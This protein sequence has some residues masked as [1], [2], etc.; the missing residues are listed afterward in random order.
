MKVV[1]VMPSVTFGDAVSNDA[2]A[3]AKV[4][5]E[6]G[7]ST[8]IYAKSIGCG[9]DDR[10]VHGFASLPHLEADDVVIFNHS[11]GTDLCRVLGELGGRKLMI[12]HNITPPEF[13]RGYSAQLEIAMQNGYLG[14]RQVMSCISHVMAV[15]EY[16]ARS[17]REMGYTCPMTVRPILIPFSDYEREPNRDV[18]KRF[19][20]DGFVNI[21]FVGRIAPNKRQEDIIR[22]FAHYKKHFGVRSRLILVGND[23]GLETYGELLRG[24]VRA[25]G[26]DD[27][28]FAGHTDLPTLIAYYRVADVF[29]CMSEHE[30]FGVPL[31]EAMYFDVPII[32]YNSSAVGETLGGSG[33]LLDSKEPELVCRIIDRTVNDA[34]FRGGILEKQRAR[35][36]DLSYGRVRESFVRQLEAFISLGGQK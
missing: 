8:G 14:T 3:I 5:S 32:A 34:A 25:L 33:I 2:R 35:L 17:L 23:R 21:L 9:V 7:Y 16:N 28:I 27:V 30:G 11:T 22:A 13:F 15:S 4:I 6:L 10:L 19:S 29:L 20:N 36:A 18:M 12:Y 26:V 1:Q 31:V 24:Y